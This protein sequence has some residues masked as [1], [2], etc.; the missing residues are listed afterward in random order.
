MERTLSHLHVEPFSSRKLYQADSLV[1]P[2][3]D[4]H[5]SYLERDGKVFTVC[6]IQV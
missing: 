3:F 2:F 6:Q 4:F 1:E 5:Y